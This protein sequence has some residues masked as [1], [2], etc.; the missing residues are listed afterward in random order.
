[1][2]FNLGVN[3]MKALAI[4]V[5]FASIGVVIASGIGWGLSYTTYTTVAYIQVALPGEG[6]LGSRAR[7]VSAEGMERMV[8]SH[9]EM[10]LSDPVLTRA[11]ET[12]EVRR[13]E[14]F[15]RTDA[16]KAV[17]K[18]A[19]TLSVKPI[20]NTNFIRLSM[21]AS[22]ADAAERM[23]LA[24]IVNAVAEQ[25]IADSTESVSRDRGQ[26]IDSLE[27]EREAL[28]AKRKR[29]NAN[30]QA[31]RMSAPVS[32][33]SEKRN[34]L[35]IQLETLTNQLMQL[36]LHYTQTDARYQA[37]VKLVESGTLGV[38]PEVVAA[39]EKD[40][41]LGVLREDE[42]RQVVKA[43][44]LEAQFGADH[45]DVKA[46]RGNLDI[47][48]SEI[49]IREKQITEQTISLL[50]AQLK[51]E[52]MTTG[53]QLSEVH[54]QFAQANA[55]VHELQAIASKIDQLVEEQSDLS[56][57]IGQVADVLLGLRVRRSREQQVLLRSRATA[58]TVH[59]KPDWLKLLGIRSVAGAGAGIFIAL[60]M[61][62]RGKPR[63]A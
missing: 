1:M 3:K 18:L 34:T 48:R 46:A 32:G 15:K 25:F 21:T 17:A 14:W 42:V 33:V 28:E 7:L 43:R 50:R 35:D 5:I 44:I 2:H 9:A 58:P 40:K 41:A 56:Q 61:L 27:H 59:N 22:A 11:L 24:E 26:E 53:S 49:A 57:R 63:E 52:L 51:A 55:R 47:I 30:I 4:V 10:I 12:E 8:A 13:T 23:Q 29:V 20:P 62:A 38:A 16:A 54:E 39:I 45:V 6:G 60:I 19:D 36:Q 31:A 37:F